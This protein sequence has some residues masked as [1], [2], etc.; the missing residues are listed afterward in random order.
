MV[1]TPP[2]NTR[3]QEGLRFDPWVG[4]VSRQPTPVFL[5]ERYHGQ[6]REAGYSPQGRAES[7]TAAVTEHKSWAGSPEASGVAAEPRTRRLTSSSLFSGD[8]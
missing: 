7:D 1:Q 5:P 2:T 3:K 8:Q 4:K 6:R